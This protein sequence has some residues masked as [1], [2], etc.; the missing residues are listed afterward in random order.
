MQRDGLVVDLRDTQGG[1]AGQLVAEKL[2]RRII[3]WNLSRYEEPLSYPVDAPR[4]PIVA[5]T[6]GYA[7]SG[8]DLVIQPLKAHGIATVRLV[9]R[10]RRLDGGEP[11]RGPGRRGDDGAARLGRAP[12]SPARYRRPAGAA[13][14]RGAG[15]RRSACRPSR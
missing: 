1:D 12:R 5:I 14:A 3:G 2:A 15:A 10:R 8:G 4:G 11:R 13:G 7:S 9:V 6:D